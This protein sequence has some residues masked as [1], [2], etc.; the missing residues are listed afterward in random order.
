M[1]GSSSVVYVFLPC[2]LKLFFSALRCNPQKSCFLFSGLSPLQRSDHC[3]SRS[4]TD[5]DRVGVCLA[6][7]SFLEHTSESVSATWCFVGFETTTSKRKNMGSR[8]GSSLL[9]QTGLTLFDE[10]GF[11]FG[12]DPRKLRWNYGVTG[13][14]KVFEGVQRFSLCT[15]ARPNGKYYNTYSGALF[16]IFLHEVYILRGEPSPPQVIVDGNAGG[17][18]QGR[19]AFQVQRD[20]LSFLSRKHRRITK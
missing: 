16:F 7:H 8:D 19:S 12:C 20:R 5:Q 13:A 2:Q 6:A 9:R 17:W 15:F 4:S 10:Y 18:L 1:C 14:T 11:P 3:C